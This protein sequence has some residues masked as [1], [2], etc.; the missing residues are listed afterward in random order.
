METMNNAMGDIAKATLEGAVGSTAIAE[1][2]A[3]VAAMSNEILSKVDMSRQGAEK[4][5]LQV[6]QFK[7]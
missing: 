3:D 5:K 2:V 6:E 1:K 4:L 7:V